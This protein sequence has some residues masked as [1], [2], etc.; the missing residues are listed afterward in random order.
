MNPSMKPTLN[1]AAVAVN[2]LSQGQSGGRM[3]LSDTSITH[4]QHRPAFQDFAPSNILVRNGQEVPVASSPANRVIG[5]T[6]R[7]MRR[8]LE[9][10]RAVLQ[11]SPTQGLDPGSI[12]HEL[13][14]F[15]EDFPATGVRCEVSATGRRKEF[16]PPVQERIGMIAREAL[17]HAFR[18][19]GATHIEAEIEYSARRFRLIVRDDGCGIPSAEPSSGQDL[20][21]S[22]LN[23]REHAE[24][25]G[26]KLTVWSRPGAGTEVEIS[27]PCHLSNDACA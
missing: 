26:A 27:L 20:R 15:V 9:E 1:L 25:I 22:L 18:Y 13:S 14:C 11:G 3:N 5:N 2:H 21:W 10:S 17:M 23:M 19:S 6:L 7:V 24:N 4:R 8:V 16:R 12:E